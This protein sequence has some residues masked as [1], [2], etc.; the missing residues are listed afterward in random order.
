MLLEIVF[1]LYNKKGVWND[2]LNLLDSL[3]KM[4]GADNFHFSGEQILY[5]YT[6]NRDMLMV[7]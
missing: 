4:V 6:K 1:L 2:W 7:K 5:H 3:S